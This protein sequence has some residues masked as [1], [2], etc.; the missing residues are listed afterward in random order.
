M[1]RNSSFRRKIGDIGPSQLMYAFGVGAIVELPN[2]SVMVMGLDDWRTEHSPEISESRLLDAI[3]SEL[4]PQV[5]RLLRPPVTPE[6]TGFAPDPLDPAAN[7]GVP[8]APFPR[9]MVCPACRLLAP[10][11]SDLFELKTDAYRQ[12]RNRYVHR[13]CSRSRRQ[14]TVVPAR[15]LV[16][17]EAGHLDDFPWVEFVHRGETDCHYQLQLYELGASGE[18]ADVQV[19][20]VRC[21][22]KRRMVDAFGEQGRSE[23]STCTARW[24]HL[25]TFDD[26]GCD[27]EARAILLGASNSWFPLQRS[28]LS[29]P[30]AADRLGQLVDEHW[31]VLDKVQSLQ[32]IELLRQV[33]QLRPFTDY[34]DEQI[35][36][37]VQDRAAGDGET[38]EGA[39]NLREPEWAVFSDPAPELNGRD[40]RLRIVDS[41]PSYAALFEKVV[42]A[43]RLREVGALIGFSRVES[44]GDLGETDEFPDEQRAPLSRGA[45]QWVPA[46]EV[47]GEGLFIQFSEEAVRNWLRTVHDLD[48]EF[49]SAHRRWRVMRRLDPDVNYP[50]LR[51]V[52]IHSFAHA[53]MR[54]L[55]LECG[56][57][58]ASIK[59]RIY[60]QSEDDGQEPMA[61]VL[62][63]TAAPDS[64]GTLGGLVSLGE[65]DILDHHIAQALEGIRLCASDPLCAE[66]R[67][68]QDTLT[69]HGAACHACLFAPE[70]SCERGNKYLDRSVLVH[71]VDRSDSA[72]FERSP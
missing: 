51:Y 36:E 16:A 31:A 58:T 48:A 26:D 59:E 3:R 57:T 37:A 43:E 62:L 68:G 45:P 6:S 7:V 5:E 1:R 23:L 41:P 24:P 14:P 27:R 21:D 11:G 8:V 60:S 49:L 44:P 42:L 63:Y 66:H 72:F 46:T 69:V 52:L 28:A 56:Y 50:T 67:A 35:W 19:D 38:A 47:R 20:C 17:C 34:S 54:Q 10:V 53:L 32:N 71:T 9:W 25:R 29:I 55:S 33:G 15:F 64:E 13:H 39:I 18:V 65:P 30:A 2:L 70:T 40:F 22:S 4:G 12:D 61:G